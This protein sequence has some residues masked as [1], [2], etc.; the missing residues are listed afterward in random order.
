VVVVVVLVAIDAV[1][2]CCCCKIQKL[3]R[4]F[5]AIKLIKEASLFLTQSTLQTHAGL[6]TKQGHRTL[7]L[8][9]GK[10]L[11]HL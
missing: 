8:C 3:T 7:R 6:R 5:H 2:G 4:C 10:S 11:I 1:D 9:M